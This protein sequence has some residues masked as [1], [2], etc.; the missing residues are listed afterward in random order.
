MM[1]RPQV[2]VDPLEV[3]RMDREPPLVGLARGGQHAES[4][5]GGSRRAHQGVQSIGMPVRSY[6]SLTGIPHWQG[7]GEPPSVE[8]AS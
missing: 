3:R 6:R 2:V 8:S 7:S 1:L 5:E 4:E